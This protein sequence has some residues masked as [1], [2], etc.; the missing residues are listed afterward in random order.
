MI[1][2][3]FVCHRRFGC[4]KEI[5]FYETSAVQ[6]NNC[7]QAKELTSKWHNAWIAGVTRGYPRM[8]SDK[9]SCMFI[10]SVVHAH[11]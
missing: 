1:Y 8:K 11:L 4:Y 10:H 2:D 7:I 6:T 3:V 9:P 5:S